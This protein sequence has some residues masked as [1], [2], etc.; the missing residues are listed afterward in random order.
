MELVAVLA[1]VSVIVPAAAAAVDDGGVIV[2]GC[3]FLEERGIL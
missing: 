3:F 1:G 2:D